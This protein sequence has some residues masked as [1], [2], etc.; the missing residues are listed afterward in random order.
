MTTSQLTAFTVISIKDNS[1]IDVEEVLNKIKAVIITHRWASTN[2][3]SKFYT[4]DEELYEYLKPICNEIYI[5]QTCHRVEIYLNTLHDDYLNY[6]KSFYAK[7]NLNTD[8][9]RPIE[10][11]E[12]IKHLFEVAAGL[13]SAVIG[14]NEVLGQVER[15]HHKALS[16]GYLNSILKFIIER[17][18]RFGKYVRTVTNISKGPQGLG[19][20]A[21]EFIKRLYK[22]LSNVKILIVGAGEVGSIVTKELYD[23][24]ARCVKILNRSLDKAIQLASKYGY[25]AEKL[26]QE[27][28]MSNLEKF[29][30]AIFAL[31]LTEPII[32]KSDLKLLKRKP[33]IIDLGLPRNVEDTKDTTVITIDDLSRMAEEICKFKRSEVE[34]AQKLLNEELNKTLN[35][36]KRKIIEIELG[37]VLQKIE[38]IKVREI[39]KS[40]RKG[41]FKKEDYEKLSIVTSSIVKKITLP[42]ID[43]IKQIAET[44]SLKRALIMIKQLEKS[45]SDENG[46]LRINEESPKR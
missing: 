27:S 7:R 43:Y 17:A 1:S 3:L 23:K 36:L 2:T 25:E 34:K 37:S 46:S 41:L 39:E 32:K 12:V 18:V 38:N 10:G 24:G 21:I 5:L 6:V 8:M 16:S 13:D 22:D 29:E 30:V 15:A 11:V 40:L 35:L 20:L 44:E 14:E 26:T 9:L 45:L 28:L 33:L 31:S 19:S 42:I 4:N